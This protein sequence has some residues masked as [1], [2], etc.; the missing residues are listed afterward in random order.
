MA[1]VKRFYSKV[2]IDTTSGCHVW[3]SAL[4][5]K[6]YGRFWMNGKK[7]LA[8]RVAWELANGPIPN[9]L[10]VLHRC[11]N[12]ACVNPE[13]LF[14]GTATDNVRDMIG[15]GRNPPRHGEHGG[16]TILT[17]EQVI[18]I[19]NMPRQVDCQRYLATL[20]GVAVETIQSVQYRRNWRHI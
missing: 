7:R 17:T 13:H 1:I 11:D 9:G 14:L 4:S 6:G 10:W 19:R 12:P 16:R 5:E 18:E 15:K 8:P 3:I 20:Y 2:R